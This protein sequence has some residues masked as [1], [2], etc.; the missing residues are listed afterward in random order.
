M[1]KKREIKSV[2]VIGSGPIIIGQAAEFDYSGT[3]ACKSLKEEGCKV[4]LVNNNPATIMTDTEIADVV[5]MENLE[6]DTLI[7]IIEKEKPDGILGTLG[8]QTGLNLIIQ[9]KDS[10]IIDKY[11]IQELGTSVESIKIAE[12]RELFK[13]KMQEIEEPIAESLTVSTV[14]EALNFASQV[15]YPLIIRPAYTLGGT[16]GGFAYTEQE[17]IEFVENG[18]KKS[19]MKEV[20]I[21]RSLLGWKEIEYE[22]VRDSFDNCITVCNMENFDPVGI[23][24]GD[25]IVVA[26]SQTLTDQEHQMLRDSSIKII[27]ALKIEGACN[28]QFALNPSNKEYRVIEVNPR[29]S[30]SSA[31]AS[32]AT[33]YPIAKIATKIALGFS[34][35]EIKNPVTGK[36]TA[37]F[38]PSLDYVV[39]KIP[40][41]PFDKFY[42]ADKKIGT[43]MKSTGETMALGRTFESSLLKAVRSLDIKIKGLRIKEVQNESDEELV[44]HLHIPNEKR[45]FHIAEALRRGYKVFDIHK[46][47]YIDN[48]FLEKIKNIVDFENSIRFSQ[49]NYDLL[50]KA[51]VLGFSDQEISEL[52]G[53]PEDEVRELRKRYGITPS[54]KMVDTCAAEF[55][56]VTQYLYSTYGEEDEIEVHKDIKKVIVIGGGPIRI[57][58]G[59]EF[60]YCTVKALWALK[61]K[62]IKSIIINNNP[63]TV[64]TDFDTGDRLYFEPLT[65]EDVLNIIEKEDPMG[66]MVMFGGQTAL[67]LSEDLERRGIKILGTSYEDIDLCEDRKRFSLLLKKLGIN[68]PRGGYVTSFDEAREIAN[69]IGFPLLVR[70]SYVIGGQSIEKVNSEDELFEYLSHALD[71][72]PNRPVLID[73]YIEGIEAEVDAVSD[74]ENVLI[75]GIMEHIEKAGIHSGDSF[76]VFPAKSL[77]ELEEKEIVRYVEKI[78]KAV[79]VKGLINIQFIV[80]E[81]KVY[82]IEVNPRASRT[83]PIISKVTGIPMIKL[84]VEIAL[85]NNL[86]ELGYYEPFYP[87]IPYTV[88]KAPIFSLEKLPGV[89]VA[90][91]AE[92]KSTG[93]TLGIDFNY[94]NAMY[95]A[96]KSARLD[97]PSTGNVLLSFPEKVVKGSKSFVKY[98]QSCGYELWGTTGTAEA[99]KLIDIKIKEINHQKSLE[100]VKKGYFSMVINLPTKGKN[101]SNFGFKLRRACLENS[102]PL[103]TA[104]ETAQKSIE[105]TKNCKIGKNNV[106]SL[107]EYVDYYHN[108]LKNLQI[109]KRGESFM[110]T[111]EK[112]VLAYSGGLDTS[113]IIPWLKEKYDCEIIAVCIDV[114]QGEETH[115]IEKKAISSGAS[116]VYVE[117]V[118]E[119]FVTDYIFPTLKAG[120]IYE[121]KYLLGT[122]FARPLMAKKLVE[123]AQKEGA[124]VIAHGCTGKGNDQVRF[125][126]S[127]KA[128]DPSIKIIAPWRIWEIKSREEEIAYAL[129]K[130]IPISITKEKI[131]SVDKNI[132]HISH[133]GGDLEDP[134]NEPKPELFDM[135]TPPEKAPDVAEYVTIEFEKGIPVKI[136][137]EELSP[138]ELIKKANEIA[139]RN[140]VGIADIVEN[141]L[142]GMKS[143]GVYETPGGTLLYTAH[144]ELESLVLDK[145]TSR[146]K[147]LVAQK[148]ADLVYNGLWFSQLK[149]SLDAFVNETQKVVTGVV[150]L[151]LYKGNIIIAGLSSPYSLYN[152]ELATFGE[153]KIYDQKD[154]EGFI[155][156]FG[157][158]LKMR[159][160]QMKH[161]V[162]NQKYNKTTVG[163]EQ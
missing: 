67:N 10:G 105:A 113:V 143:R 20:L 19:M 81:G 100:L 89:E 61:E 74:G 34:L 135:V 87:K 15:G 32:K 133:E 12:S 21:E 7:S 5:Y 59:V 60:D 108:L 152:E 18:L 149:E 88:V 146:F 107:N 50:L 130:G 65:Q 66:T 117:D 160:Y 25:S 41:W 154:A 30:R 76:A 132:W 163:G 126:V 138:V 102:I 3:Q 49:L 120:A 136:N 11:D 111:G 55:D 38:E 114:G 8:G 101:V 134:W 98:L 43:Q 71:L 33:G 62:G 139:S 64:S 106:Q 75:P 56:S 24:T 161:F 78:S 54:Y 14:S 35:D 52:K 92:M 80:K 96:F 162:E 128:L 79:N 97:V 155:N 129:K 90:L 110:K 82:V 31:L 42:Q 131:Y 37:F 1:P 77:S 99:F 70:P 124:N 104:L 27:K 69:R 58:Q 57:G 26:P 9:L 85:G 84:A 91:G 22:L 39:T 23:H 121:G 141:R 115:A 137:E 44:E 86:K 122:S 36:T 72:S 118:V 13:R 48:W 103:F 2:L 95:K 4:I 150:K 140:G 125:E 116:K 53:L 151:K 112:V 51:K 73:E 157:L 28:I 156:L 6:M 46:L 17:L 147:D 159:A 68:H 47:T 29:L 40:R 144:K 93:E 145:E 153:D 158:P 119:E 109:S 148:Y 94:H 123:I 127:I 142:V 83:V 16:G 63:E 45:L